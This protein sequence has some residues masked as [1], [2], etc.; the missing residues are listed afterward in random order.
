[1][2]LLPQDI[3][4]VMNDLRTRLTGASD[5]GIK[6]ELFNTIQEFLQDTNAW[7]ENI[8]LMVTAGTQEY[9]L[10]PRE[11]GQ[12]I[13]LI[14]VWDGFRSP[15]P[16]SMPTFGKLVVHRQ[17]T[18]TSVAQAVTD[19]VRRSTT[20]WLVAIAKNIVLPTT[21]DSVPIA[22]QF[23]LQV[24]SNAITDGV[25]GRMMSQSSKSW[26]N[27]QL[28]LYHLKR[29]RDAIQT[30]RNDAWTQNLLGGQRW[31]FPQQ[32]HGSSQRGGISTAWPT[33]TF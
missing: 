25:L 15:Q 10:L 14:G 27:V 31:G 9:N 13:R 33:E 32:F 26:T 20:P 16:S 6:M 1:M 22:P 17:V 5:S 30:A 7:V 19:T 2:P 18:V 28:S 24:Y 12:V 23:V 11:G 21:K 4:R 3:D 8:D 29:F